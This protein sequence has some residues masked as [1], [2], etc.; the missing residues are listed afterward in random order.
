MF[1]NVNN[2]RFRGMGIIH[3]AKKFIQDHMKKKVYAIRRH[4][5]GLPSNY[6]FSQSEEEMLK[7]RIKSESRN[8]NL[9]EVCLCFEAFVYKENGVK[10]ICDPV[11]SRTIKNMSKYIIF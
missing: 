10:S 11:F 5:M 8:I 3:T 6:K 9:N 2:C 4:E 1:E 7:K